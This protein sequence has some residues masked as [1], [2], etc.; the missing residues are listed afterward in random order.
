[1]AEVIEF[2]GMTFL[3]QRDGRYYWKVFH[4][5]RWIGDV[6]VPTPCAP[7]YRGSVLKKRVDTPRWKYG[8]KTKKSF[9]DAL[10][11]VLVK[12]SGEQLVWC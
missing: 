8:T 7:D 12:F 11:F 9:G 3:I 10:E 1:M 4:H 5:D 2:S 6:Q